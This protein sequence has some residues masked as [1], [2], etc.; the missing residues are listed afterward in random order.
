MIVNNELVRVWK[1]AAVAYL[2]VDLLSTTYI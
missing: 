2:K 1:Y